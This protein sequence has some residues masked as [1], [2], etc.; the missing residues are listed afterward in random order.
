MAMRYI[1]GAPGHLDTTRADM[2]AEHAPEEEAVGEGIIVEEGELPDEQGRGPVGTIAAQRDTN[3][4]LEG[5]EHDDGIEEDGDSE[6]DIIPND[7]DILD[8]DIIELVE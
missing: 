6:E 5:L 2:S 4:N 3:S 8:D 7:A 1:G